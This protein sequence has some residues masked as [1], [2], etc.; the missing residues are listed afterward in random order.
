MYTALL[1]TKKKKSNQKKHCALLVTYFTETEETELLEIQMSFMT[2][3]DKKTFLDFYFTQ[4]N[5]PYWTREG[6]IQWYERNY[7]AQQTRE[8]NVI[9]FDDVILTSTK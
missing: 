1:K 7:S 2:R 6:Y 4:I 8:I 5:P 3:G 9:Y